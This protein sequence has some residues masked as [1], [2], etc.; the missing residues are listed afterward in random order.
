[1]RRNRDE[2]SDVRRSR[3]AA[4]AS[5]DHSSVVH[6]SVEAHLSKHTGCSFEGD[7]ALQTTVF[8][9]SE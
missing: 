3:G 2:E 6:A 5:I 1:M 4:Y 9:P 8:I 7:N